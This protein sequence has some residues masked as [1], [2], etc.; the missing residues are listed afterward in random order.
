M[1]Q[2]IVYS[3]PDLQLY[4][5]CPA[6]DHADSKMLCCSIYNIYCKYIINGSTHAPMGQNYIIHK[7]IHIFTRSSSLFQMLQVIIKYNNYY[8][9]L[10]CKESSNINVVL[11]KYYI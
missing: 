2:Y 1:F 11:E 6:L 10:A 7:C 5:C 9:S 8:Y 4:I 3:K